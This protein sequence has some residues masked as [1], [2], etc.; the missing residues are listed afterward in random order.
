MN[1]RSSTSRTLFFGGSRLIINS[2]ICVP[3]IG[4]DARKTWSG[5]AED[6]IGCLDLL[7][8][9]L[10]SANVLFYDHLEP[11]ERRLELKD[12]RDAVTAK[13]FAVAEAA[14]ASFGVD[15]FAKRFRTVVEQYRR[16]SGVCKIA[17]RRV[18]YESSHRTC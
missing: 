15:D 5:I 13:E 16:I 3:A 8:S 6:G 10:P 4:A 14:L 12:A 2:V 7:Q 1:S 9:K 17:N 18:T 11:G